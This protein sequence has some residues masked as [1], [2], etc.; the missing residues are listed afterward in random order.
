M[1]KIEK[2]KNQK[3]SEHIKQIAEKYN[4]YDWIFLKHAL[5]REIWLS[6]SKWPSRP[7]ATYIADRI[8]EVVFLSDGTIKQL[9]CD[10]YPYKKD[11]D[12]DELD[13]LIELLKKAE[14]KEWL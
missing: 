5:I 12:L 8:R 7:S 1:K 10:N 13:N 14:N 3:I 2:R 6:C 4:A 11:Q 9:M